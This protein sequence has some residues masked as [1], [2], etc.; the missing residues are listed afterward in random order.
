MVLNA[1]TTTLTSS[2]NPSVAGTPVTFTATVASVIPG[3]GT[4]TG[5]VQFRFEGDLLG[6]PVAL[7]GGV[8][9]TP[10]I[11]DLG[12]GSRRISADYNGDN[13]FAGSHGELTQTVDP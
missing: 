2:A 13:R 7:V 5:T 11:S 10:V 1:T 4:P 8:A 9:T 6:D 12:V 3:A